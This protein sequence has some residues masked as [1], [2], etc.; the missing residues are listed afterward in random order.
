MTGWHG[1][2]RSLHSTKVE[3]LKHILFGLAALSA[4]AFAKEFLPK[5]RIY[6]KVELNLQF[7]NYTFN[8]CD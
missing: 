6:I 4:L 2:I 7:K 8:T 3:L 1:V 5:R